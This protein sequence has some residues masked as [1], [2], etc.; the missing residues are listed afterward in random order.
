LK[1]T[2]K[3]DHTWNAVVVTE[4]EPKVMHTLDTGKF[5]S[6]KDFLDIEGYKNTTAKAA[7]LKAVIACNKGNAYDS[8]KLVGLKYI[9]IGEAANFYEDNKGGVDLLYKTASSVY[10]VAT[11]KVLSLTQAAKILYLL[12]GFDVNENVKTFLEHI[13]GISITKSTSA[14]YVYRNLS[15]AKSLGN[16]LNEKWVL[17]LI[18]KAWNNYINGNPQVAYLKYDSSLNLPPIMSDVLEVHIEEDKSEE[19]S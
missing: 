9:T 12:K 16:V 2:I 1:A 8:G 5:R 11:D 13:F 7:I 4:V 17:G 6:L 18:I 3:A 10:K 15:R 19:K 14:Y